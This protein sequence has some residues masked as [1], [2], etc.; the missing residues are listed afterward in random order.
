MEIIDGPG[1]E[2]EAEECIKRFGYAPE[3]NLPY[4]LTSAE[5][6]FR[7]ILL[8]SGEGY[9]FFGTLSESLGEIAMVSEALAPR[10][11]QVEVLHEALDTCFGKLGV[12]KLVVE[13]DEALRAATRETLAGKGYAALKPRYVLYWPVFDMER[14]NGDKMAGEEWKK[15]R[16][17][18][19]RFYSGH[20]VEMVNSTAVD[21][22]KLRRIVL[23]WVE[24]RKLMSL[25]ASRKDSNMAYYDRYMQMIEMGFPGTSFAK[26]L[27][28]DGEPCTITAGWEV[29]NSDRS[30]YSAIGLSNY[31]F[32]GLG[33]AANLEDLRMLKEAGYRLVDFGGS[34]MP[35]LKFKLKFRPHAVY[36]THTY[37]IVRK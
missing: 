13:Q 6:G 37:A 5:K 26:T 17:I 31:R 7:N 9:G 20:K 30:Y 34:P 3:H 32:E 15:L 33:E 23:E 35:L 24:R 16:N 10:E 22:E 36:A 29:P 27:L 8:K 4:F 21:R 28:V 1:L 14:W 19:N 12:S 25:G 18:K 2:A 11:K